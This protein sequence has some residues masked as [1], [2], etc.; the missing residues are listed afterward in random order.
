MN[1]SWFDRCRTWV[2]RVEE[3]TA[4]TDERR[5]V[6]RYVPWCH[7]HWHDPA[8]RNPER[9]EEFLQEI[10]KLDGGPLDEES[11]KPKFRTC[12]GRWHDWL[13]THPLDT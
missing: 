7:V 8:E 10:R 2:L 12:I 11:T 3:F 9:V 4:D 6:G 1:S 13:N 5:R